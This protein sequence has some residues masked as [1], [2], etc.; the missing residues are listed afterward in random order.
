MV[1]SPL[2]H[3]LR[4]LLAHRCTDACSIYAP[5]RSA[6]LNAA[7]EAFKRAV[8]DPVT[9]DV[10]IATELQRMAEGRDLDGVSRGH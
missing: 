2:T 7:W 6:D 5:C 8:D 4:K 3:W 1:R 9:R 10:A